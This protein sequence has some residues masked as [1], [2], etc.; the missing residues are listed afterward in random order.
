MTDL[1]LAGGG[2]VDEKYDP[3]GKGDYEQP[4]KQ[5]PIS[6]V[7]VVHSE[8]PEHH[9]EGVIAP[10]PHWYSG[11][12]AMGLQISLVTVLALYVGKLVIRDLLSKRKGSR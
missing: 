6:K 3:Y 7:I 2:H 12:V 5:E 10:H 9:Q 8:H 11:P 1:L 4:N